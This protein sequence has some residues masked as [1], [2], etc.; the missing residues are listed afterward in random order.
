MKTLKILHLTDIH[1][2]LLYRVGSNAACGDELCCRGGTALKSEH[3]AGA[4]GDLRKCDLPYHTLEATLDHISRVH[5]VIV[6]QDRLYI[7]VF[8]FYRL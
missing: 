8:Q 2:D 7:L 5:E 4:Y 6:F 1:L 3:A